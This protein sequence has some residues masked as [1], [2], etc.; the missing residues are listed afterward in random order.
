MMIMVSPTQQFLK[1]YRFA[2][3][4]NGSWNHFVNIVVPTSS[5]NSLRL[6]GNLI[7]S[8]NFKRIGLS[9]Y[10]IGYVKI[11]FGTHIITGAD[12]FGM[13]SYGFGFRGTTKDDA[14]DAYGNMGGQSFI[15]Y[16]I[17]KDSLAPL[18]DIDESKDSTE[19]IVRDD[20][21]N[22]SGIREVRVLENYGID[23]KIDNIILN[24]RRTA[25][26]GNRYG[27]KI[28]TSAFDGISLDQGRRRAS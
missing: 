25:I 17:E 21:I 2:T 18:V 12:P 5:I 9:R 3:P 19:I 27:R 16:E 13:Y 24:N 10:S 14:Y 8:Q 23:F 15:E 6:N 7:T 26:D 22:D 4:I 1:A 28:P 20:R 11:P